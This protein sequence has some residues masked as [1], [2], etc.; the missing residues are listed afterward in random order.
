[1]SLESDYER[2]HESMALAESDQQISLY[3]WHRTVLKLLPELGGK[4]VLEVGCG[5]GD[6]ARLLGRR[7]PS[8]KITATDFSV[9]AIETA[10]SK[11]PSD[12]NV[13]FEVA[14]AQNLPFD[15]DLFDYIISCECLEHVESPK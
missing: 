9:T 3:P 7:Y 12:S 14:D 4:I 13:R 2:W 1:M 10:R 5:R 8:A 15:E 11:L 6:F